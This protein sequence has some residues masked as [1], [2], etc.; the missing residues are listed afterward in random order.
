MGAGTKKRS[1]F[2]R[3]G[4]RYQAAAKYH[5]PG[6]TQAHELQHACRHLQYPDGCRALPLLVTNLRNGLLDLTSGTLCR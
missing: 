2:L 4:M 3:C 1:A 5:P 6:F